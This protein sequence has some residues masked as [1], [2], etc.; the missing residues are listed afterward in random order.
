V[1]PEWEENTRV[2]S[3]D[4]VSYGGNIFSVYVGG[5]TGNIPPVVTALSSPT[6]NGSAWLMYVSALPGLPTV[7][8]G[9]QLV[10]FMTVFPGECY[11]YSGMV[12]TCYNTT[13][14]YG[15]VVQLP[16]T[17]DPLINQWK[18]ATNSA[19]F[20][21]TGTPAQGTPVYNQSAP[22][23]PGKVWKPLSPYSTNTVIYY[24]NFLYKVLTG[25]ISGPY[26]PSTEI[27]QDNGSLVLEKIYYKNPFEGMLFKITQTQSLDPDQTITYYSRIFSYNPC[28]KIIT[29]ENNIPLTGICNYEILSFSRD[30][31]NPLQYTLNPFFDQ[32][33]ELL[34][35]ISVVSLII[36]NLPLFSTSGV[37]V[38]TAPQAQPFD[39]F[40]RV[41]TLPYVIVTLKN[42]R[43]TTN[44]SP[45]CS[46]NP[47]EYSATFRVAV[48]DN[49]PILSA[50]FTR[51]SG[52]DVKTMRFSPTDNIRI[53]ITDP[54]GTVLV[55]AN[56]T[57]FR[58]FISVL[59]GG[60]L[61]P[62][63]IRYLPGSVKG[64]G[65]GLLLPPVLPL[66][67]APNLEISACFS[68][69]PHAYY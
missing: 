64:L 5:I 9:K 48:V 31:A 61:Y 18:D 21:Q 55:F 46:N 19:F 62:D 30:N 22:S 13:S 4:Y 32:A 53:T 68:V 65:L 49:N 2:F 25:G 3:G 17:Y 39:T 52:N 23:I 47:N 44:A 20:V 29:T 36:P 45:D 43:N 57:T 10:N 54:E 6:Q 42:I 16:L 37:N 28:T 59:I 12:Y 66:P 67:P 11:V 58:E 38:L 41:S 34:Y 50:P 8:V 51:L 27:T 15:V 14:G 1:I 56:P 69:K 7:F 24:G 40:P 26:P 35:D 60:D 33:Q 63:T